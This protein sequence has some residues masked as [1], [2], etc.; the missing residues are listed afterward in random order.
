[1]RTVGAFGNLVPVD[2]KEQSASNPRMI[3]ETGLTEKAGWRQRQQRALGPGKSTCGWRAT[4]RSMLCE[5]RI[6]FSFL[7]SWAHHS[8]N[9]SII[10]HWP[11]H[12]TTPG[13]L[14][15]VI[16]ISNVRRPTMLM[17]HDTRSQKNACLLEC[18][19]KSG[20]RVYRRKKLL[21]GVSS[22]YVSKLQ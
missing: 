2:W 18:F 16:C 13:A 17:L 1:M 21:Q 22:H 15:V 3:R 7:S 11:P 4:G 19:Y 20:I 9:I 5:G 8:S 12:E 14:T 10:T 6:L